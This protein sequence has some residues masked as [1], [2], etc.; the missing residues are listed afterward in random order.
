M[1]RYEAGQILEELQI[2]S[3]VNDFFVFEDE[4]LTVGEDH[5]ISWW[6]LPGESDSSSTEPSS[7]TSIMNYFSSAFVKPSTPPSKPISKKTSLKLVKFLNEPDR[8]INKILLVSGTLAL[9]EDSTH[10]RLL[11]LDTENALIIKILKGYRN[12]SCKIIENT[13]HLSL[14]AGNKFI[15]ERWDAFP[16]GEKRVTADDSVEEFHSCSASFDQEGN[17]FTFDS[18]SL[19][20]KLYK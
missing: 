1:E 19:Q 6:K 2:P 15:L 18:E 14:W 13:A 12:C 4:I 10:G 20:L 5:M 3:K 9:L 17:F 8:I 16:F 7:T 11:V